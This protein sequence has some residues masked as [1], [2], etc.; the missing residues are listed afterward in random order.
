MQYE[1]AMYLLQKTHM[2]DFK[3]CFETQGRI[4]TKS[5]ENRRKKS[6]TGANRQKKMNIPSYCTDIG[7][8]TKEEMQKFKEKVAER[9]K[10]GKEKRCNEYPKTLKEST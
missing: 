3:I 1:D 6:T 5:A 7:E 2:G 4:N 10:S 8:I 9:N